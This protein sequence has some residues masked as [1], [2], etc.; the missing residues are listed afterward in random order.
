MKERLLI[1]ATMAFVFIVTLCA[2]C[3]AI[4]KL[5]GDYTTSAL[6]YLCAVIAVSACY[7]GRK[8]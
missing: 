1:L 8:R 4:R 7:V 3:I 6:I 2:G 5:P